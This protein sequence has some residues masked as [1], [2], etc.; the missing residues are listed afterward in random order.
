MNTLR[1]ATL[2]SVIVG[3]F[4]GSICFAEAPWTDD[5][6]ET[7]KKN[8]AEKKAVLVD[9]REKG[10]WDAGHIDGAILLPLIEMQSGM[11]KE[12]ITKRLPK[13][14]IIYTHCVK[15][16]RAMTAGAQ[17][18]ELGYQVRNLKPGYKEMIQA[19][20]TKAEPTP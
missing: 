19:G 14:T 8:I 5:S 11:T 12:E 15:G 13:D 7:V 3:V 9:V 10:E 17:L 4:F 18:E 20:F 16:I 2:L 1:T 6:L